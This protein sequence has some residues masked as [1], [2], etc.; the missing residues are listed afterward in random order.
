MKITFPPPPPSYILVGA[1]ESQ[2]RRERLSDK[3]KKIEREQ[4]RITFAKITT[5]N[6]SQLTFKKE[7]IFRCTARF[8]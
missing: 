2:K 4:V 7:N 5:S 3:R 8:I 1:M 6:R